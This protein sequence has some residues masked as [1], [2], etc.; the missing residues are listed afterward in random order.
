MPSQSL[1]PREI[2]TLKD[3]SSLSTKWLFVGI[4]LAPNEGLETGVAVL[5]RGKTLLRM[6]K[7][8]LNEDLMYFLKNLGPLENLVV[9]LD[10]PKSL[11]IQGRWRQ[12]EIKMH[13]LR[14]VRQSPEESTDRY[15]QRARD[16]YDTL[17]SQGVMTFLYYN[18]LAKMRYDLTI[19]YRTRTP[20]GCR[21]LQSIIKTRLQI[22]NVPTNLA[23]SSVLDAMVGAYAAWSVYQ[24]KDGKNFQLYRDEENR[25]HLEPLKRI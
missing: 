13:P 20:Q 24:G 15:S 11:N 6:D 4:D 8:Y 23:P 10:V 7:I 9:A 22:P 2:I 3:L 25:I 14:L 21:A 5:E 16:L 17:Q 18:Y 1:Y 12:E 19:P